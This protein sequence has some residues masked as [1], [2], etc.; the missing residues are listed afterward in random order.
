MNGPATINQAWDFANKPLDDPS[1]TNDPRVRQALNFA[2]NRRGIVDTAYDGQT[3][4]A[5]DQLISGLDT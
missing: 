2:L 3:V 4:A 5:K 1:I